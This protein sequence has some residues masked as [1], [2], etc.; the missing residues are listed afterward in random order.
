MKHYDILILT[1]SNIDR[2]ILKDINYLQYPDKL[3]I[4]NMYETQEMTFN[5]LITDNILS[6]SNLKP[7]IEESKVITNVFYETS[8]DDVFAIGQIVNNK[9]LNEQLET[10][11]NYL[12][13][14]Y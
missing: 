9:A 5:Y 1:S 11:I 12:K 13:K 2:N 10:I 7:L 3:I 14:P 4:T 8:V 6:I